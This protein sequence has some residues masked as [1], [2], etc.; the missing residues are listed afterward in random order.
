MTSMSPALPNRR[1]NADPFPAI[2][3]FHDQLQARGIHLLVLPVPNKE[4]VY[5][6]MLSRRF[7]PGDVFVSRQTLALLERLRAAGIEVVDLFETFRQVKQ[8]AQDQSSLYLYLAHDSHWSPLGMDLAV[9]A[10]AARL[11][12]REW[13]E[14]GT[15]VYDQRPALL[16][17]LGDLI[18]MLRVPRIERTL[19][20]ESVDCL[21]VV[22]QESGRLYQDA[23]DA[24][25]LIMGDSFL[26]ILR[27]G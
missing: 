12:E 13:V 21:Q 11:I 27:T 20:P 5:P 17:R 1:R 16:Q 15:V 6:E 26:R 7:K 3:S 24:R 14:A 18:E 25:I 8:K 10:V 23:P 4:S 22:R 2:K 9:R 19:L